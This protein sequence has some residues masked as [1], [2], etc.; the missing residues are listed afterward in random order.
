MGW[1][2][3]G[4]VN[5]LVALAHELSAQRARVE[6]LCGRG[7]SPRLEESGVQVRAE[8]AG[9]LPTADDLLRALETSGPDAV[10]VDYMLTDALCAAEAS[11]RPTVALVHTL[12]RSL[13][14]DG[15]PHP[16]AMAGPVEALNTTRAR[17]GLAPIGGYADL[18][19][20]TVLIGVTTGAELDAPGPVPSHLRYLGPL[21][22]DAP[23]GAAWDPPE[24]RGPLVAVSMGTGYTVPD[25]AEVTQ[26]ILEALG[27]LEV[28]GLV[29]L[30]GYIDPSRL[31]A[32]A[33]VTL[34]G[35]IPHQ[36][37]LPH[38]SLLMTHAGLGSV[39]AALSHGLP[40]VCMPLGREQPE[41]AAAVA[42]LGRGVV[43]PAEA[44]PEVIA[45]AITEG[46]ALGPSLP[47]PSD[48]AR[49]ARIVLDAVTNGS[50]A[51]QAG[52]TQ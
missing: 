4:N 28:R 10:V 1:G 41:N 40:M 46:L 48:R 38:A 12:Y 29:N 44:G 31:Q 18:L 11:G 2:G 7:L 15:A 8:T 42:G 34:A 33:N 17:L 3:G 19:A 47:I 49:A 23:A 45:R 51:G 27:R 32:P 5:P 9:P 52:A 16:M 37:T 21:M 14:V 24:G 22:P 39:T 13:L 43:I 50:R 30:P 20:A 36:L 6:V 25:E 35:L 26:R